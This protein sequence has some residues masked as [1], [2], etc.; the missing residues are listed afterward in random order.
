MTYNRRS[1]VLAVRQNQPA[2]PFEE[3]QSG[4]Q[5][6]YFQLGEKATK[7]SIKDNSHPQR[8]S[9]YSLIWKKKNGLSP[10]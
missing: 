2:A 9:V 3:E 5:V 7:R 8:R 6:D 10:L 1:W 4:R